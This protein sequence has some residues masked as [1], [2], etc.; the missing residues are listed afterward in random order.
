M[1]Q[2]NTVAETIRNQ[3]RA[4]DKWALGAWG[5]KDFVGDD[6]SLTFTVR[7]GKFKGRVRITLNMFDYYDIMLF[8]VRKA[9]VNVVEKLDNVPVENLVFAL[10]RRIG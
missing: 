9:D 3:I 10:D 5:A 1:D 4:L 2:I 8:K 7:G 6:K